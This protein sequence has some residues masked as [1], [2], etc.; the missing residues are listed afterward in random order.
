MQT[1][2]NTILITGGGTGIGLA[3]AEHFVRLENTVIV[4]GRRGDALEAAKRRIPELTIRECDL[5][6]PLARGSLV[7]WVTKKFPNLNILVNNAGIQRAVDL[8]VGDRDLGEAD[9]EIAT[10]L[11]A[12]IHL[13][14]MLAP[15]LAR[16]KTAAIVN[17]S[18]GLA[19]TPIATVPVYC[20]TKAAIHS[21][22][23][24]LRHQLRNTS[25][26][27]FEIIPPV[28][29]TD[30]QQNRPRPPVDENTLMPEGVA[31]GTLDAIASNTYEVA[32]GRAAGLRAKR[33]EMFAMLNH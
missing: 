2:G 31:K 15:H 4:C 13:T 8:T 11:I 17:I 32:L 30:L 9:A 7:N 14:A 28:V 5:K 25:V 21:L 3:L 1:S 16:Q 20:A 23:L 19:F 6:K 27:V 26:R 24:S 10:N 22:S 12:P 29:P 18:S 33:E